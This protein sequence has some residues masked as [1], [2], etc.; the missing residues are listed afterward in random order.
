MIKL[1]EQN[2]AGRTSFGIG[3]RY[4]RGRWPS[5]VCRA[6]KAAGANAYIIAVAPVMTVTSELQLLNGPSAMHPIIDATRIEIH[7]TPRLLVRVRVAGI[8]RS[9]PSA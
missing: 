9:S 2:A 1:A 7:G 5:T 4:G 3:T 8:S 6:A